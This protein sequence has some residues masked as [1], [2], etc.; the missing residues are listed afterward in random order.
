ML[1]RSSIDLVPPEEEV[2]VWDIERHSGVELAFVRREELL[3]GEGAALDSLPQ[4]IRLVQEDLLPHFS[5]YTTKND[6]P[7]HDHHNVLEHGVG[8]DLLKQIQ[9]FRQAIDTRISR[10]GGA[11]ARDV[12]D[13]D[14]RSRRLKVWSAC[15][16]SARPS[17]GGRDERRTPKRA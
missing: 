15:S 14:D 16:S 4:L 3:D 1:F 2:S 17:E 10:V 7:T 6:E 5:T 12:G 11:V 9:S 8:R 13:E